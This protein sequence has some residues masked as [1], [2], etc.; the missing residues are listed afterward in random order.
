MARRLDV[1][2]VDSVQKQRQGFGCHECEHEVV[3]PKQLRRVPILAENHRPRNRA[4]EECHAHD[5]VDHRER[6]LRSEQTE[7]ARV[8]L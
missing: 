5:E 1:V 3:H 4:Q 8:N 7:Q 2:V 6:R